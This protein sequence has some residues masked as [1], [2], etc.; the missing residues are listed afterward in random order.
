MLRQDTSGGLQV[1]AP[2]GWIDAPPIPGSF[3]CNLG[4]MLERMTGGR[5]RSTPHRVRNPGAGDRLS[6]PFFFDPAWD[7]EVLPVPTL[8]D[9]P[10]PARARWDGEDP[11][12]LAGT[13]G[14]YL[15]TKVGRVFPHLQQR[16]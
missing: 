1:H 15:W 10:A 3:V 9:D 2:G 7:A 8:A 12:D 16:L 14:D 6:V 11:A 13:Y 5:Y 4:D